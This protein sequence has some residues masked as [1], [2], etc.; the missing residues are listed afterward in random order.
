[1]LMLPLTLAVA[2]QGSGKVAPALAAP[3]SAPHPPGAAPKNGSQSSNLYA[4][5]C[6]SAAHRSATGTY[7]DRDQVVEGL[8]ASEK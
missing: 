6:P 3:S 1:M 8:I 5:V 7:T 2:G 4:V